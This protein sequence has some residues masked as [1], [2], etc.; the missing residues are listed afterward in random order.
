M[1]LR[2]NSNGLPE[3]GRELDEYMAT[4][5]MGCRSVWVRCK[6]GGTTLIGG[7]Y[8]TEEDCKAAITEKL[9][10]ELYYARKLWVRNGAH[11][12][13]ADEWTPSTTHAFF[14]VMEVDSDWRWRFTEHTRCLFAYLFRDEQHQVA[15]EIYPDE[16]TSKP[17][18]ALVN[19]ADY[20]SREEA[21][22]HAV[23]LCGFQ[24]K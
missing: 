13:W 11:W 4:K 2:L 8:L 12:K 22:A 18:W 1:N 5:V 16:P 21:Y 10:E 17:I 14:Q 7:W 6:I 23:C 9:R 3:P 19:W 24:G 15:F 20:P